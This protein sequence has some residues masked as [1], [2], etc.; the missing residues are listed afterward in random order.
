MKKMKLITFV[1]SLIA[2]SINL[3]ALASP[4][5][6]N[7]IKIT[8]PV[9][10]KHADVVFNMD[11]LAFA[12]K[13]PT[14]MLYMHLLSL[15]M[16][17]NHVPGRIIGVFH[18]LAAYMLLNNTAYNQFKHVSTGNPYSSTIKSLQKQG[19][20]IEECAYSMGVHHWGN[21]NLLPGV[22]VTTGAVGRIVELTQKGYVQIQP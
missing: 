9:V 22:Q 17:Q 2:L 20:D 15:R 1:A 8:V 11:H 14:G 7:K 18:S 4:V 3:P 16:K 13:M 21:D 10:L 19:V 6:S 5:A 12:G